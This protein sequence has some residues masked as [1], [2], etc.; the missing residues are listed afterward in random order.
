MGIND[1]FLQDSS[2]LQFNKP[3]VPM[4]VYQSAETVTEGD[5]A[6]EYV[7]S[8]VVPQG[9]FP[10]GSTFKVTMAGTKT[11]TNGTLT[12][13]L[14]CNSTAVLSIDA[15]ADTAVDWMAT[16]YMVQ[17]SPKVQRCF[18]QLFTLTEDPRIDYATAA[19]DLSGEFTFRAAMANEHASDEITCDVCIIEFWQK[20]DD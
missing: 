16:L 14:Y 8:V 4:I 19:I 3:V 7:A 12:V 20:S 1:R 9:S 5:A 2:T 18:G 6:T 13:A 10:P 17:V 15:D 11:G